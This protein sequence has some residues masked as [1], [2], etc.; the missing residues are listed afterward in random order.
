MTRIEYR[1]ERLYQKS[2]LILKK[3]HKQKLIT[4]EEFKK[5]E[6]VFQK[7]YQPEIS[8]LFSQFT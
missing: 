3:L 1:N 7:K 4:K 5:M 8:V 6:Q 2:M